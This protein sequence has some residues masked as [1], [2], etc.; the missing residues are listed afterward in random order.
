MFKE[1]LGIKKIREEGASHAVGRARAAVQEAERAVVAAEQ[2]ITDHAAF[3]V[4]EKV[5][6]FDEIRG[7]AVKVDD[8]DTMKFKI[9]LLKEEAEKLAAS[10]EEKK[11]AVATA[12]AAEEAA[13]TAHREAQ[14]ATQKFEEFVEIQR[15][16]ERK[17]AAA[18]GDAE[19]EEAAEAIFAGRMK[20]G[21]A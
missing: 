19:I 13:E 12:R 17:S 1:L 21:E 15:E 14:R 11:K 16:E 8:I 20:G 2:A 3:M 10:V 5:R 18:A 4:S 7:Q 6:L 9:G